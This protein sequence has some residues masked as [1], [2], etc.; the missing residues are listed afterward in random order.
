MGV[1]SVDYEIAFGFVQFDF[2]QLAAFQPGFQDFPEMDG[3]VFRGGND[4]F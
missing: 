3:Q 2:V 4:V 1:S